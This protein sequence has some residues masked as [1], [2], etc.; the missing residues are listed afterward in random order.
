MK[1]YTVKEIADMVKTNPETVRRW[2][3]QGYLKA[4]QDS[5]RNGYMVSERMLK[6]FLK[7]HPKYEVNA[8]PLL[9]A[10]TLIPFIGTALISGLITSKALKKE[11][12]EI[13]ETPVSEV[14]KLIDAELNAR[15]ASVKRKE[16]TVAQLLQEIEEEKNII[17]K[18]EI[19]LNDVKHKPDNPKGEDD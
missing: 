14:I 19:L 2:I 17:A 15:T 4:E 5:R 9:T 8:N 13:A 7:E 1:M 3:R 11:T 10:S 18:I 12:E 6:E 16:E